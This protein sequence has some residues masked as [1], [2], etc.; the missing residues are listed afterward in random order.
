[1]QDYA[2]AGVVAHTSANERSGASRQ[3][4]KFKGFN[5]RNAT[6]T[7]FNTVP[8]HRRDFVKA[9]QLMLSSVARSG[10]NMLARAGGLHATMVLLTEY[11]HLELSNLSIDDTGSALQGDLLKNGWND[12]ILAG[13]RYIRT[14]KSHVL[15]PGIIYFITDKKFLGRS[16]QWQQ[17]KFWLEK[18]PNFIS[19]MAWVDIGV[20][21]ANIASVVVCELFSGSTTPTATT[22]GYE[23]AIPMPLSYTPGLNNKVLDGRYSPVVAIA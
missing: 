20:L 19:W 11:D 1:M 2:N 5:A 8:L 13:M 18:K 12:N 21:I 4:S 3:V 15:R 7:N 16:F 22:S 23:N 17:M 9:K 10:S 14:I 6:A